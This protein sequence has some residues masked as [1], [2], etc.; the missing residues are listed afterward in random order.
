[1]KRLLQ[2]AVVL[3]LSNMALAQELKLVAKGK[4]AYSIILPH[5][6]TIIEVQAAKVFQDYIK[7]ISGAEL[8]IANDQQAP[9][10]HEVWIGKVNRPAAQQV[11]YDD[12]GMDGL[13]IKTEG[14]NLLITG[15]SKKGVI[16]GVYHFLENY[17]GCRKY[18]STVSYTPQQKTIQLPAI[19]D[20]QSPAFTFRETFYN[21]VYDPEFMDWHKLHSFEGRGSDKTQWGYWVHTFHTLL[22]PKEYGEAHPEY[23]SFYKGERHAA[24]IPNWDK[25]GVQPESQLCLTNPDVLEIVCKNLKTAMDKKP[26]ALYWSVS[27]N[28]NV[29][30]CRCDNCAALDKQ[31]AAFAPEEKMYSTHGGEKYPALGS[32]SIIAFVNKVAE[33]F[34][35]KIISTLAYQ[36]SRVPPKGI[37]PRKNVNI[38]LCSIESSRNDPMEIG[39]PA[40][41][42]DLKGWGK[43]T[44]NILIWDYVIRFSNLLAPFPNLRVLQPNIQFLRKNNVSALFEQGNI[45]SGGDA[46]PL[47]AYLITKMLWNPEIDIKKETDEFLNAYYGAA[48]K[49]VKEYIELLHDN[50]QSGKNVKLSIFGSPV[51]DKET[52]LSANLIAK[53]NEI[54]DAAEK[55]VAKDP[56]LL[57]RVKS[58]RLPVYY[59][60]LEIAKAEKTG[61]R[62]AFIIGENGSLVANPEIVKILYDFSYH[63]IRTNVSRTAEWH[64]PPKEY[65]EKYLAFLAAPPA[66]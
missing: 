50:N 16:Y 30:Y 19:N 25:T 22:D 3:L 23:F 54:F 66:N 29:N 42:D 57:V 49:H 2:L 58:A 4:S 65:L 62:G 8:P 38:M 35:D 43:I 6:A 55:S 47:R 61:S 34:P 26:D 21:D 45:Q 17:L 51:Q 20:K 10:T 15:G 44:N 13:L 48:T 39:D 63:C 53:Y 28:D 56:E 24:L 7:R 5:K 33:R 14:Q 60:I 18:T 36:Y 32:G 27:Q 37:V 12:F 59:G 46:A 1:M 41:A 11:N 52:F 31:Y 40:F 9:G 64:T